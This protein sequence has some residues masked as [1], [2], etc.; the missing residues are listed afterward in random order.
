MKKVGMLL[1]TLLLC[2]NAFAAT[3][4]MSSKAKQFEFSPIVILKGDATN[5]ELQMYNAANTYKTTIKSGATADWTMTLPVTAGS[6]GQ[7]MKTDGS[8]V[9]SWSACS[10]TSGTVTSVDVAVPG[11]MSTSGGPITS[12]G[13][14]TLGLQTQT[15]NLVFASPN[16]STGAPSFRSLVSADIPALSYVTSVATGYGLGGGPITGAGTI[17][18]DGIANA[19]NH[20]I[21][22]RPV[23]MTL[24]AGST[25]VAMTNYEYA[26]GACGAIKLELTMFEKV[27]GLVSHGTY[28]ILQNGVTASDVEGAENFARSIGFPD[29]SFSV[30]GGAGNVIPKVSN[31]A[32][33]NDVYIQGVETCYPPTVSAL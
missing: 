22:T 28:E 4:V 32:G 8:G 2:V 16:G 10:S 18:V 27:T 19:Q 30:V 6:N 17:T 33:V 23:E 20:L 3:A 21:L 12:A 13:T 11:F 24:A 26:D 7:C 31:A 14:I 29:V 5:A 25:A 15:Q 1:T 9:T